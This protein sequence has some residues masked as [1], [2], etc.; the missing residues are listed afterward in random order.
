MIQMPAFL[1]QFIGG[2][3]WSVIVLFCEIGWVKKERIEIH[4]QGNNEP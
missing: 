4:L 2:A 3:L 1:S